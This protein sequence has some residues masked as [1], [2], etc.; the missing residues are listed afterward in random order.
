[1]VRLKLTWLD[2]TIAFVAGTAIE[3]F[4]Y[5]GALKATREWTGQWSW[6]H[7]TQFAGSTIAEQMWRYSRVN[8][9]ADYAL[10]SA[11]IIQSVMFT[12]L[13]ILLVS[14]GRSLLGGK[15]GSRVRSKG[16]A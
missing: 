4:L 15:P 10:A 12:G 5:L 6:F 2:L 14:I 9:A 13:I 1:M 11:F 3:L 7:V 8:H 16:A